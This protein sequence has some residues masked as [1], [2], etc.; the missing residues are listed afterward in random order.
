MKIAIDISPLKTGH[1]VRGIGSY[2]QKLTEELKRGDYEAKFEF[3]SNPAA[4]PPA[5]VIHYPYFDLFFHTLPTKTSTSRVVTIHDVIPLV[6]PNYFPAAIRGYIN[7]FFQKRALKNT[8]Y[9]ICDSHASKK[10]I[11][12]KLSFPADRVKVIYLA[13]GKNFK[14][15]NN[16]ELLEKVRLKYK[17][18]KNFVLFVGDV[19]WN[20][21]LENLIKAIKISDINLVMVGASLVDTS[22]I[23]VR[24]LSKL[25]NKL[26]LENKVFITGF[27]KESD[28]ISLYNLAQATIQPS[29]YEGFGLPVIE[30]MSC[31]TPVVCSNTSSLL[32]IAKNHAFL[33][34]PSDPNDIAINIKKPL[35]LTK[36]QRST[37][38]KK[39]TDYASGF[40]WKKVADQTVRVYESLL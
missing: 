35:E 6:F 36:S 18:P 7:L 21:N 23:Q 38:S 5:D 39:L 9:V 29:Y 40:T 8:S 37:L 11:C 12:D 34:E 14:P 2:T 26:N 15:I 32:E 31:G 20:K 4:P 27:I 30:S 16:A 13:A 25:I 10:D 17:L 28:L 19:N 3:F 33:C 22:L 24:D 1:K